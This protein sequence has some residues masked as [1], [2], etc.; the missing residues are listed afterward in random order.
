MERDPLILAQ[1][2]LLLSL[3]STI[4]DQSL[5]TTWLTRALRLAKQAGANTWYDSSVS[6][7]KRLDKKKLWWACIL[8]DRMI[9]IGVRRSIQITADE[10]DFDQGC[11]QADDFAD[12]QAESR[13][14]EPA[15]KKMLTHIVVAQSELAVAQTATLTAAYGNTDETNPPGTTSASQTVTSMT[16]IESAKTELVIWARRFRATLT[17]YTNR[18]GQAQDINASVTIFA[19]MTLIHY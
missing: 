1:T 19:E 10:V 5:N 9:A 11:L 14:Y 4:A 18:T 13:V 2:S 17:R 16:R 8:R 12:E 7:A 15:T 6:D 3:Q